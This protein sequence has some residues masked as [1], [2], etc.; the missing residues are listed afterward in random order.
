MRL[1]S[2]NRNKLESLGGVSGLAAALKTSTSDGVTLAS[3]GDLSLAGRQQ[4]FGANAFKVV[5]QKAFWS[6]LFENL[7]DPTL[8]LL[9]VAALV[10]LQ[11]SCCTGKI[12]RWCCL[13]Q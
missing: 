8:I 6:L 13:P 1:Q 5:K 9:M 10:S 7:Q 2:K 12:W 4:H 3:D 11:Q